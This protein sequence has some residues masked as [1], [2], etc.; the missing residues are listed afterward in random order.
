LYE[1]AI[2]KLSLFP[3]DKVHHS[4]DSV[5][6]RDTMFYSAFQEQI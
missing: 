1:H 4:V 2:I 5:L 6:L 3:S